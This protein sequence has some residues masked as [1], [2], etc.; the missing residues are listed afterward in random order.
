[1]VMDKGVFVADLSDG[2]QVRGLFAVRERRQVREYKFGTMFDLRVSDRTGRVDV[3]FF[4]GRDERSVQELFDSIHEGD[5]IEVTGSASLYKDSMRITVDPDG[6]AIQRVE[7]FSIDDFIAHSLKDVDRMMSR[8]NQH[9]RSIADPDISR[10]LAAIFSD[11]AFVSWFRECPAS[12][13]LHANWIGGL[14]EHTLNVADTC[15]ALAVQHPEMDRDLLLAGAIVHDLGKLQEYQLGTSIKLTDEG[16]LLGHIHLGAE[17][18]SRRCEELKVPERI[19]W[20]LTHMVLSSHGRLE[21]GSPRIPQFAEAFALHMADD[22]DA[23]V[24]QY[25]RIKNESARQE[26]HTWNRRL[27]QIYLG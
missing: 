10:L 19:R 23:K 25:L 20:K 17:M 2:D 8:I 21:Y 9:I 1:M 26:G 22:A 7:S 6:G 13:E 18:V 3:Y 5:V 24:E 12:M 15:M 14:L 11:E 4:G 27:G 16:V